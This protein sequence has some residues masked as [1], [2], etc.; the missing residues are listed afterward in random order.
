MR[1]LLYNLLF[2]LLLL[3]QACQQT[4]TPE[5][6]Y[7]IQKSMIVDS[8]VVV[9]PHPLSSDVGEAILRQG[10]NA[11]DAAI[12]VQFAMAVVFPRAGN[13]GGG[14]FMVIR[15]ADGQIDALDYREEAPGVATHDMYLDSLGN[16]IDSMSTYGH[17][18]IGVPGTVAGMVTAHEKYGSLDWATLVEPAVQFAREGYRITEAEA[19]RLN[20]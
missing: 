2:L 10:G 16:I 19:N 8:A 7:P 3:A 17:K 1:K 4:A 12:A 18:A 5:E 9:S 13:I 6:L 20:R 11:V 14:G 15:L